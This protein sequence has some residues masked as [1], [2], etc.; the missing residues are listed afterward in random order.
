MQAKTLNTVDYP[1]R[2]SSSLKTSSEMLSA[3]SIVP[4]ELTPLYDYASIYRRYTAHEKVIS[5]ATLIGRDLPVLEGFA[6]RVINEEVLSY[7]RYWMREYQ[8]ERLTFLFDSARAS[9]RVPRATN[10]TL[11]ELRH[12]DSFLHDSIVAII[13]E[14]N[15][16]LRQGYSVL[17][18]FSEDHLVFEVVGPGFEANDLTRGQIFPHERILV[19]RKD[20]FDGGHRDLRPVDII[21]HSV[22]SPDAYLHS[23]ELRYHKIY[24]L[25]GKG[26]DRAVQGG[27]LSE[28]QKR[29]VESL[30]E[31][32]HSSLLYRREKY[33]PIG[34]DKLSEVYGYISELNLFF[35]EEVRGKVVAASF[36]KK[37]GLVFWGIFSGKRRKYSA[38]LR[39]TE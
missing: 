10:P 20:M 36:L 30:L 19:K 12:M 28:Q 16:P 35:P 15:D 2:G 5:L 18:G 22:V 25:M 4:V 33:V 24:N 34:F 1:R 17:T 3:E 6:T 37:Q 23:V 38:E 26:Q 14:E 9:D 29:E 32:H 13:M 8:M 11:E 21:Q 39:I 27:S 7:L 31:Q